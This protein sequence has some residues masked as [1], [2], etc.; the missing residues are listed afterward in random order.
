[1]ADSPRKARRDDGKNKG[2]PTR[3]S[4]GG[5]AARG[6]SAGGR[7][8]QSGR[9]S[10]GEL[11]VEERSSSSTGRGRPDM[12]GAGKGGSASRG[13]SASGGPA[14]RSSSAGRGRPRAAIGSDSRSGD[15]RGRSGRPTG[16]RSGAPRS[17]APVVL[18][19]T[20]YGRTVARGGVP[21]GA[22]AGRS[23]GRPDSRGSGG[24]GRPE[25]RRGR[26]TPESLE[27][28]GAP[29]APRTPGGR[30][31]TDGRGGERR[32]GPARHATSARRRAPTIAARRAAGS[33]TRARGIAVATA[34]SQ[35]RPKPRAP[36]LRKVRRGPD[37]GETVVDKGKRTRKAPAGQRRR[38]RS[39]EASEELRQL[40]G[41]GASRAVQEL[42]RAAEAVNAGHERDAARILRPLRDAYPDAA[43]V[44]EL[45]GLVHYRLG[46]YPA[47][48]KEL[49]TFA[50]LTGSVEQHPVMMDCARAQKKYAKVAS[51]WEELAASSPSAALVSE[52][53]IVMAG[54]LAD[55]GRL[56]DAVA[57]LER[58]GA[59]RE[60]AVG[61]S[62]SGLVRA[63]RPL[64]THRRPS[65]RPRALRPR[66]QERSRRSPT[67]PNAS[68]PSG[69]RRKAPRS[70]QSL[71]SQARRYGSGNSSTRFVRAPA[72][73]VRRK[74]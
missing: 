39:T 19:G 17:G 30:G 5:P 32:S 38:M 22:P 1:M 9:S 61:A 73:P 62:P 59:Q 2:K 70:R 69:R 65:S 47:A 28:A 50:D 18:A 55:R 42:A 37:R 60:A 21:F 46:Q 66:A 36:A 15:S 7:S 67:S 4:S 48:A 53:R 3:S 23:G 12:R 72:R 8:S 27:E 25:A 34:K 58:R 40:A 63:R 49:G 11:R 74:S 54:S 33:S 10:S 35:P 45:L 68:S 44:R 6:S 51:L 14:P 64:R 29:R 13:S 24:R 16:A 20:S 57:M 43:A 41:R 71:L 56:R 26:R 52:G 31:R